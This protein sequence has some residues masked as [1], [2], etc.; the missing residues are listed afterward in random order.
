M[1]NSRRIGGFTTSGAFK[2]NARDLPMSQRIPTGTGAPPPPARK[3]LNEKVNVDG[4]Q[5]DS[6]KE[7][8]FYAQL[9]ALEKAGVV[10]AI[11]LQPRFEFPLR[12]KPLRALPR[13]RKS[14]GALMQG[15]ALSYR[16]DFSFEELEGGKWVKRVVDI[17][18]FD[19]QTSRLKRALVYGFHGVMVEIV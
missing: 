5:F 15:R 7:A 1:V 8:R 10:R 13:V 12:G 17:K 3:Y 16:A 11:Q 2:R 9:L 18:G 14:D 4:H 6:K 19:T